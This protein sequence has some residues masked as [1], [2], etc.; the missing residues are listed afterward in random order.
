MC[1]TRVGLTF[2][3]TS[4]TAIHR[5]RIGTKRRGAKVGG[6]F[7][8]AWGLGGA[9]GWHVSSQRTCQ[10]GSRRLAIQTTAP[11]TTVMLRPTH[12]RELSEAWLRRQR[13][14][15]VRAALQGT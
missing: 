9:F 6:W 13:A 3:R 11:T 8:I 12:R 15:G 7:L 2:L 10:P 5:S 4:R 14:G 1:G